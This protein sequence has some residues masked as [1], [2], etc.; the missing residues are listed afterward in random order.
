MKIRTT[1][2]TTEIECSADDLRQSNTLA[3]SFMGALRR[4][5]NGPVYKPVYNTN[6]QEESEDEEDES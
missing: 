2:I 1:T 6:S 5:F 3:E 4:A